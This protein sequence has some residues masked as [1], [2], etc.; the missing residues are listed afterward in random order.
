MHHRESNKLS[1]QFAL[2]QSHA[3]HAI[4]EP[5]AI[6]FMQQSRAFAGLFQNAAFVLNSLAK[7]RRGTISNHINSFN[8]RMQCKNKRN[9]A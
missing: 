1:T 4:P 2:A 3:Q 7:I 6:P 5:D 8:L 9:Q